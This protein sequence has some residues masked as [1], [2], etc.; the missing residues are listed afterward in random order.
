MLWFAGER[1]AMAFALALKSMSDFPMS[2]KTILP[3]TLCFSSFSLV[4]SASTLP[5]IIPKL[6]LGA[7]TLENK[8]E[9]V[10]SEHITTNSP[11]CFKWIKCK[12]TIIH[13]SIL[14]SNVSRGK[15]DISVKTI[16]L[17]RYSSQS[18]NPEDSLN[19]SEIS[20][21]QNKCELDVKCST[22][23]DDK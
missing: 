12:L 18:Y 4:L 3:F 23:L 22:K 6:K 15:K 11:M 19:R 14:I 13:N 8:H 9:E 5:F 2:G 20:D 1:G 17:K 10:N 21:A 7:E 16:D